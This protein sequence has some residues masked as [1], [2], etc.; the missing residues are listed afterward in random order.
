[1]NMFDEVARPDIND[2]SSKR[3]TA[4]MNETCEVSI[5]PRA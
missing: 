4:E 2:P 1:M 3:R 5:D